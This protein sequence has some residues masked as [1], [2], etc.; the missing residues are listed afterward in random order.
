MSAQNLHSSLPNLTS[1]D[2]S[3]LTHRTVTLSYNYANELP[4]SRSALSRTDQPVFDEP[5]EIYETSTPSTQQRQ[6]RYQATQQPQTPSRPS[7]SSGSAHTLR[8]TPRLDPHN[9]PRQRAASIDTAA[10]RSPSVKIVESAQ[11]DP[12]LLSEDGGGS[13]TP[14]ASTQNLAETSYWPVRNQR[15]S[16][17]TAAAIFWTLEEALR[18][19]FQ[20]TPDLVEENASM[21]DL[22]SGGPMSGGGNGRVSNGG[23][24]AAS[25]PVPVPQYPTSGMRTPT[26]IM[27]QRRDRE[28]R[29]K[30]EIE[31]KQR[32][33]E[34][35]EQ[36][37]AQEERRSSVERRAAAVGVAGGAVGGGDTSGQR[38]SAARRSGGEAPYPQQD[39]GGR[40][41]GERVNTA[42]TARVDQP[43]G[44]QPTPSVSTSGRVQEPALSQDLASGGSRV[45]HGTSSRPRGASLSQPQSRP[46][47]SQQPRAASAT[48]S[49]Q[50]QPSQTRQA[51]AAAQ[52]PQAQANPSAA[53]SA[54]QQAQNGR[55]AG[56]TQQRNPTTSS[57][58]HAFERWETLSSHWEGLTAYWIR[59]L[60]ENSNEL[61]RDPLNQQMSRQ[62]TDLSAA[63]ANLFHAVVEL[64]RLRASSERKFQRWFFETRA[65]QER[66]QEMQAELSNTLR[67]ERQA[68]AEAATGAARM[69]TEKAT[70]EQ[71]VKEMRRELQISKEEARRAWEELGRREQEERDR[72]TSLRNGEPTLV[73]GVQVVPMMQG[74]PSRQGSTNRPTNI[75]GAYAERS[76][77]SA[78]GSQT[79]HEEETASS[80]EGEQA[81]G[82]Y[83]PEVR[84]P[85]NTDPFIEEAREI[86]VQPLYQEPDLPPL[87]TGTSQPFQQPPTSAAAASA[88]QATYA[89]SSQQQN[90]AQSQPAPTTTA[91][92]GTYLSYGP[93]G[94]THPSTTPFYQHQ[95][96][97]LHADDQPRVSESDER[98][99]VPSVDETVS[100]LGEEEY[101]IDEHGEIRRDAQGRPIVYR[102]GLGSEDSDEFDVQEALD[103]ER[104]Y[105]QRYG[106]GSGVEYGQGSTSSVGA[107]QR[108]AGGVFGPQS[109]GRGQTAGPVS[110][111]GS[112]PGWEAVPRHHHPTRLS[113]VLE[114]DER[115]RTS[116]SRAS[117]TS[118]G[119]H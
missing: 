97:A 30:A 78:I 1:L 79:G 108:P 51:S 29:K 14:R 35:D 49:T 9:L 91:S 80:L 24:R 104:A 86:S 118:R 85:T 59:R 98:S 17:R 63:G 81:Y 114:E 57:F 72:T 39:T 109:V 67:L 76:G 2:S 84:S 62:I 65:E 68:R 36:R 112:G 75:G 101:E 12:D 40:R 93:A 31:A 48:Y 55:S 44:V 10:R 73:G 71:M 3:Y 13:T 83:N 20:F 19:P 5:Y 50:Q 82:S 111:G 105:G 61:A 70:A 21:S 113:D 60:Q 41:Q 52:P 23:S 92:G 54:S 46:V 37:K 74:V 102:R 106:G 28:A 43:T 53:P 117:Q 33:L 77:A 22:I 100:D 25:G 115:S 119:F 64:Q 94:V 107:T 42:N 47:Q 90:S 56:G 103:R 38:R 45:L 95:G 8:R 11:H 15:I 66:A 26:D 6:Q 18:E 99:Y 34:A 4:P 27:R 89:R 87:S 58:P 88:A 96:S 69:E 16:R 116:P 110:Y 7:S 32:E